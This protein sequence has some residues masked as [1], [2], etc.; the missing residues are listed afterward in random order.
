MI[1]TLQ[2]TVLISGKSQPSNTPIPSYFLTNDPHNSP[3]WGP[4][5]TPLPDYIGEPIPIP[6]DDDGYYYY[7]YD[8]EDGDYDDDFEDYDDDTV[9]VINGKNVDGTDAVD[10]PAAPVAEVTPPLAAEAAPIAA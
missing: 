5:W 6:L 1:T 2:A 9:I 3:G 4:G 8:F 7:D 10:T